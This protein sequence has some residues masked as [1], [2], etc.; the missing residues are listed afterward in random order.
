MGRILKPI[1]AEA[2]IKYMLQ[3][4]CIGTQSKTTTLGTFQRQVI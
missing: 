1:F 4:K 2:Y 3:Q